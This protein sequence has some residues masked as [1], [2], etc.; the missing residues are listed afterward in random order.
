LFGSEL[1]FGFLPI[2]IASGK[3]ATQGNID[4]GMSFLDPANFP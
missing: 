1:E 3:R 2:G 4:S